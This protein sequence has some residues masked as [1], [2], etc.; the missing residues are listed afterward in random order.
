M[1]C[2]NL[3]NTTILNIQGSDYICIISF[4]SKNGD[5]HLMKNANLTKN[6]NIIKHE[7]ICFHV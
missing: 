7:K 3:G 1:I 2:V 6:L 4:I 5:K